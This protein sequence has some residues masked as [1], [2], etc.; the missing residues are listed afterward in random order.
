MSTSPSTSIATANGNFPH[1]DVLD[2]C[3]GRG[4]VTILVS[5]ALQATRDTGLRIGAVYP[6]VAGYM[7]KYQ[8]FD[9]VV[10]PV[11]S[12]IKRWLA[13]RWSRSPISSVEM[14]TQDLAAEAPTPRSGPSAFFVADGDIRPAVD[15]PRAVGRDDQRQLRWRHRR[16]CSRT[17]RR[18]SD[19]A[20]A[21]SAA[22]PSVRF[23]RRLATSPA[24]DRP[25]RAR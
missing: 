17:R 1:I 5:E 16:P 18:R 20:E 21:A 13:N 6:V 14:T 15:R 9:D 23:L 8:E 3:G 4:L 25:G 24:V 19:R 10:D 7:K 11:D 22:I 12:A 2:E